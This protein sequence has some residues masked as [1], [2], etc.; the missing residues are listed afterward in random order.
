MTRPT[1]GT[2]AHLGKRDVPVPGDSLVLLV[3]LSTLGEC[4]LAAFTLWSPDTIEAQ[5]PSAAGLCRA[6]ART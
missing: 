5:P 2:L 6:F 3:I 1:P 4:R